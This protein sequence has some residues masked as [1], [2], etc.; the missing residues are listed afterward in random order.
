MHIASFSEALTM[1][2][3]EQWESSRDVDIWADIYSL[4][5][6]F[7]YLLAGEAP[8]PHKK[9]SSLMQQMWATYNSPLPPIHELRPDLPGPITSILERMLAKERDQRF[10][11]PGEVAALLAPLPRTAISP[12]S[13]ARPDEQRHRVSIYRASPS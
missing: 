1:R 7:Y 3:S 10:A 11:T 5:C 8:F 2:C 6:K 12:N 4:G 13:C 9:Y